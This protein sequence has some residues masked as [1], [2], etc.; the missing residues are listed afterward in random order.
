MKT[1]LFH[2]CGHFWAF[3]ICWHIACSIWT[4]S[5]FRIWNSSIEFH[6]LYWLCLSWWFLGPT[7]LCIPGYLDLGEWS[8]HHGYLCHESFLYSSSVYSCH[9]FL[10]SSAFV[11]SIQFLSFIVPIFAWNFPLISPIYLKRSLVLPILFF[12]SISLHCS[13]RKTFLFLLAVLW[14]SAFRWVIALLFSFTFH[15]FS[16]NHYYK[17][18]P[19]LPWCLR[20]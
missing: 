10:L 7:W 9:L 5:S 11:R 17:S 19:G 6:H 2:S 16:L 20:G 13:L 15:F 12:S 8:H 1:D 4:K 18:S 3:Q 14:K